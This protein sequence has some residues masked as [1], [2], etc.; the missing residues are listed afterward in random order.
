[1]G[2]IFDFSV[3]SKSSK[4][5]GDAPFN[6]VGLHNTSPVTQ[7]NLPSEAHLHLILVHDSFVGSFWGLNTYPAKEA[8][9]GSGPSLAGSSFSSSP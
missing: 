8:S 4:G 1:M 7:W 9:F 6:Y 2:G 5:C 3:G